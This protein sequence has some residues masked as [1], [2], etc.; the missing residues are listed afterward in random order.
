MRR[1]S[2]KRVS[3]VMGLVLA[4]WL[5]I[6]PTVSWARTFYVAPTG[7]D[8]VSCVEALN[9]D[10]P[11]LTIMAALACLTQPGETIIIREG[12]YTES[13]AF[14]S[15][16]TDTPVPSGR[17]WDAPLTIQPYED[18]PVVLRPTVGDAVIHVANPDA[19][20]VLIK[21]VALDAT[22]LA[23]GVRIDGAHQI[24]LS[25]VSIWGATGSGVHVAGSPHASAEN[26]SIL[27]DDLDLHHNG[28][29]GVTVENA[30]VVIQAS[31]IHD[32][33]RGGILLTGQ[34]SDGSPPT[35]IWKNRLWYNGTSEQGWGIQI[36]THTPSVLYGNVVWQH[37]TGIAIHETG[38]IVHRLLNNT[39]LGPGTTGL[40]VLGVAAKHEI[41][42]NISVG[43]QTNS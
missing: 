33:G 14:P 11:K 8:E 22:G 13:L 30:S 41:Q 26:H 10:T 19:Q 25:K 36:Q 15:P 31:Q 20:F 27:L 7:A 29:D 21:G 16:S 9:L 37:A 24:R 43:H 40:A 35:R 6:L 28:H 39:I 3:G 1:P 17:S 4:G 23:T 5:M 2:F 34:A 18:E 12:V 42:N 32:N 38:P